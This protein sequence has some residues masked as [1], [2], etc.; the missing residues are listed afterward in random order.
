VILS[1]SAEIDAPA[2]VVFEAAVD[3]PAQA[4]WMPLTRVAVTSGDGRSVGTTVVARTGVGPAAAFDPMVV[5]VWQPPHRCEVRH[6]GRIVRGRGVFRVE[7]LA[8]NRSRFTWEEHL[9]D[10]GGYAQ[11]A[12]LSA[13]VNRAFFGVAVRRFARWVEAGRP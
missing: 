4:R 2:E 11:L 12:R 9:P 5:D 6:E 1:A 10:R 7:P 8:H 3:W 13:R